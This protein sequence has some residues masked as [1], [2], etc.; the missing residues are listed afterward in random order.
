[1]RITAARC[2]F[3]SLCDLH[4]E[5][6]FIVPCRA[7][8]EQIVNARSGPLAGPI[9]IG[10]NG[11]GRIGRLVFRAAYGNPLFNIVSINDPFIT[12]KYMAYMLKV[13][14][15]RLGLGVLILNS[16]GGVMC[17]LSTA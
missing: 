17:V 9:N 12:A 6:C 10:I 4:L 14:R 2:S 3:P 8:F 13:R 15:M 16:T 1:M 5:C 7:W 11:F